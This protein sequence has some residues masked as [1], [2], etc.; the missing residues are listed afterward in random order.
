MDNI[1]IRSPV[2]PQAELEKQY[3]QKYWAPLKNQSEFCGNLISKE[4]PG[5][6]DFVY[7]PSS[8]HF[9]LSTFAVRHIF[10]GMKPCEDESSL[11]KVRSNISQIGTLFSEVSS[12]SIS[13][14]FECQAE[15]SKRKSGQSSEVQGPRPSSGSS[16][17]NL[18][19]F[20]SYFLKRKL[21][22]AAEFLYEFFFILL[23][24]LDFSFMS[25]LLPL[26]TLAGQG[27]Q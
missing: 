12:K 8:M 9:L 22:A 18:T 10:C 13:G 15:C 14:T 19:H 26:P 27:S 20:F 21:K 1:L 3:R 7:L 4:N 5:N 17:L 6:T 24:S 11:N 23:M 25:L 2:L 16:N